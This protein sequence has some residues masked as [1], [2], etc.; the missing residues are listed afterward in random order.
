MKTQLNNI[1]SVVGITISKAI[2]DDSLR[3]CAFISVAAKP[4]PMPKD[5]VA[6][7]HNPFHA[8]IE[9]MGESAMHMATTNIHFL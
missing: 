2:M 9:F 7:S 1:S 3:G 6:V 5:S 4:M 8:D